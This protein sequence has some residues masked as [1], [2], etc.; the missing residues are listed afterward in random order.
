MPVRSSSTRPIGSIHRLKK[1]GPTVRRS[2][3]T[4]SLRVG[5]IVAK[6]TKNAEKRRIQLFTRNAASRETH[7]SSSLRARSS[8][9]R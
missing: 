9:R 4:A 8:G 6:S 5:N 1:V 2:P 3:R 7:E